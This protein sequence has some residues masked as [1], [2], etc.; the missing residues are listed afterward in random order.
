MDKLKAHGLDGFKDGFFQEYWDFVG[1][2]VSG[3]IE[4]LKKKNRFH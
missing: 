3:A 2:N 1:E 4:D